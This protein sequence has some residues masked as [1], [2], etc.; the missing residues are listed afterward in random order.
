VHAISEQAK[1]FYQA[2]GF[3]PSPAEPMTF[4]VTLTAVRQ[5]LESEA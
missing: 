5:L 2:I 4:M 1:A 3:D